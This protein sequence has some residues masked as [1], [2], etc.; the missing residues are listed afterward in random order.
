MVVVLDASGV[1]RHRKAAPA[2][3]QIPSFS[4]AKEPKD[5]PFS[6]KGSEPILTFPSEK[7]TKPTTFEAKGRETSGAASLRRELRARSSLSA[8]KLAP[9]GATVG[10]KQS[11]LSSELL[12]LCISGQSR[13]PRPQSILCDRS[14]SY[15]RRSRLV[16]LGLGSPLSH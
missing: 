12:P 1:A 5:L 8:A 7:V 11:S 10:L 6:V 14:R 3:F 15:L 2:A 4:L 16:H 13:C 9:T